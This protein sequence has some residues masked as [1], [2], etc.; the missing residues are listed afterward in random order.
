MASKWRAIAVGGVVVAALMQAEHESPGATGRGV[1]EL[2]GAVTP[3]VSEAVGAAG[4]AA[5]I[6]RDELDRQG[7]NPGAC[8]ITHHRIERAARQQEQQQH[9]GPVKPGIFA[10]VHRFIKRQTGGQRDPD[11]NRHRQHLDGPGRHRRRRRLL[12]RRQLRPRQRGGRDQRRPADRAAQQ[13]QPR[14]A[15]VDQPRGHGVGP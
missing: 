15:A 10:V 6:A 1:A 2:R 14:Q 7:I 12:E 13:A 5:I 11:R 3:A 9:Q 4:D 8:A